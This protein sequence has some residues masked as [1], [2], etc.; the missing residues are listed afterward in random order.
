MVSNPNKNVMFYLYNKKSC[1][2]WTHDHWLLV[3]CFI[4][5]F[6]FRLIDYTNIQIIMCT[7]YNVS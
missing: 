5:Y 3:S 6:K 1:R 4:S 7:S 2:S